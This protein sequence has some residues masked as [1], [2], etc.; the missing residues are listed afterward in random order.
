MQ[1]HSELNIERH[2]VVGV[3]ANVVGNYIQ[4][5]LKNLRG[6]VTTWPPLTDLSEPD[7]IE[8]IWNILQ[9]KSRPIFEDALNSHLPDASDNEITVIQDAA[10]E[11]YRNGIVQWKYFATLCNA[12][13]S[14]SSADAQVQ[15]HDVHWPPKLI[16]IS[17]RIGQHQSIKEKR[18]TT[19]RERPHART[20][21]KNKK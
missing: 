1:E 12:A 6:N 16:P 18:P 19:K 15:T 17:K 13:R 11:S 3:I 2:R 7:S 9:E 8:A 20:K 10:Q 21:P 4:E 14:A 5:H